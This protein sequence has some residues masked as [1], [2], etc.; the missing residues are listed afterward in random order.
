MGNDGKRDL[1]R[2]WVERFSRFGYLTKGAVYVLVG[3]L[4]LR[5][6]VSSFGQAED[7]KGALAQV[8]GQPWGRVLLAVITLGL[9][10]YVLWRLTQAMFDTEEKGR[11]LK[12][13]LKRSGYALSGL[14]YGSLA[15]TAFQL[16]LGVGTR[17]GDSTQ[18]WTAR[19]LGL[20]FG[21]WLIGAAGLAVIALAVNAY[22]VAISGL[23][24]KKIRTQDMSGQ[25]QGWVSAAG[26]TGLIAR[27]T[28]FGIVGWF[29]VQAA[30]QLNAAKAG[31]SAKALSSL[32]RVPGGS[33]LLGILAVGVI[34]Y[35]LYAL[36][37]ARYREMK[38]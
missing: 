1:R 30:W 2:K 38:L 29:L 33:W 9:L 8:A 36:V 3:A 5:A 27:G 16:V 28:V 24:L 10:G 21:R 12:G 23:Y 4:T 31:D 37:Q 7:S 17:G 13:I 25:G 6:A 35:G 26:A 15:L 22:Y 19:L 18:L 14:A 20:P 34:V 11:D 32:E